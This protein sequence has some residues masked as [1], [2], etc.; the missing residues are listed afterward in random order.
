MEKRILLT[1]IAAVKLLSI[2]LRQISKNP[3]H[4]EASSHG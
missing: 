4:D 2:L 1:G 3:P